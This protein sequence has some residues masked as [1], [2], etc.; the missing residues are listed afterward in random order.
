MKG[1]IMQ[2]TYLSWPGYFEMIDD[3]DIYVVFDH[4][5]FKKNRGSK[6]IELK[7]PMDQFG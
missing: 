3:S 2:P 7:Q 6:E 5:Q 1:T 4:V